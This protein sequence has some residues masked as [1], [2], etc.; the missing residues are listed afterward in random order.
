MVHLTSQEIFI[1]ACDQS[2]Q[3]KEPLISMLPQIFYKSDPS[4]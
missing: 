4:H 2:D 3:P 1:N